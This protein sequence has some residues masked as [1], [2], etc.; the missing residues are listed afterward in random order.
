MICHLMAE[1]NKLVKPN[2]R[3][4]MVGDVCFDKTPGYLPWIKGFN[5]I[6]T[7]IRG[8]HDR[9]F[10]NK[11][12]APYFVQIID[13]GDGI[14]CTFHG[15]KCFI[16]HY[17]SCGKDNRFNLVGHVHSSWKYQPNSLN[18][19]VD[20]HHFRPVNAL[21]IPFHFE[22][23]SKFFDEDVWSAYNTINASF[24]G[25]RGKPGTYFSKASLKKES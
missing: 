12:L 3:V 25:K 4:F 20:V 2:D 13:E 6:K 24:R 10:T 17:P 18:I 9:I 23:V 11:Q 1:H 14:A 22:A 16:T 15:V 19:G 5:G 7:L 8:N 21:D